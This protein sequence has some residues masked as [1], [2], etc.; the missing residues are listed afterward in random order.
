MV[1]KLLAMFLKELILCPVVT[2]ESRMTTTPIKGKS[3]LVA[4][5]KYIFHTMTVSSIPP[6]SHSGVQITLA[7]HKIPRM[8]AREPRYTNWPEQGQGSRTAVHGSQLAPAIP[9]H[10]Y[11]RNSNTSLSQREVFVTDTTTPCLLPLAMG[12]AT[13]FE[14]SVTTTSCHLPLRKGGICDRCCTLPS[15]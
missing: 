12:V 11:E 4:K 7:C 9:G 13:I 8:T 2:D 10:F 14:P 6:T 3:L 5:V 15:L 1:S